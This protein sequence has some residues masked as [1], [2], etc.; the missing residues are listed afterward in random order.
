[1]IKLAIHLVVFAIGAGVGV[2]WGVNHP[3]QAQN[4]AAMEQT[5]IAQGKQQAL[6]EVQQAQAAA[7]ASAPASPSVMDLV[8]K[9]LQQANDEYNTAKK[10]LAGQ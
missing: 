1:M 2:W 6:Q 10:Q 7:P 9:R 5:Y 3:Q 8:Q 4:I